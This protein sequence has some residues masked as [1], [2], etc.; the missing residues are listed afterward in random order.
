MHIL[1]FKPAE[2]KIADFWVPFTTKV[3]ELE[4]W[5]FN[6]IVD[7]EKYFPDLM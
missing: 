1:C 7:L 4:T 6:Q 5:G 2:A 3:I